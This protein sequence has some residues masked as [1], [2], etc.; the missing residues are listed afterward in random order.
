MSMTESQG[1]KFREAVLFEKP[2]QVIGAINAYHAKL[3]EKVGYKAIYLSGGGV[4]AGSL[5]LPDLGISTLDDVTTDLK[6]I[7][8]VCSL[9][10]LVDADT[11]FGNSAFNIA[12][13]V[14]TLIKNGKY[15]GLK[16]RIDST[17]RMRKKNSIVLKCFLIHRERYIWDMSETMQ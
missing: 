12:R 6:R 15:F 4:A 1:K 9:P 16:K 10:V 14:K 5:G 11:G 8:D 3:A 13:T 17:I 2:L 7:T